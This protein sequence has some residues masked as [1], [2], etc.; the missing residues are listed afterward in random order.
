MEQH[1][2]KEEKSDDMKFIPIGKL[3]IS[4]LNN[5]PYN[6]FFFITVSDINSK[7]A[8]IA[9]YI[10]ESSFFSYVYYN[11][12][13][14]LISKNEYKND[15]E[16]FNYFYLFQVPSDKLIKRLS[17]TYKKSKNAVACNFL[18]DTNNINQYFN[19]NLFDE[20]SDLITIEI[21]S[22]FSEYFDY[23]MKKDDFEGQKLQK[24]LI[25][26]IMSRISKEYDFKIIIQN[27][28]RILKLCSKF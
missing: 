1:I 26:A 4:Q 15:K 23:F 16:G 27:F 5:A 18:I 10:E 3:E 6:I 9:V 20:C 13:F 17:I 12:N 2:N 21:N 19:V 25:K 11:L 28:L 7:S 8:E 24:S 14:F 22:I